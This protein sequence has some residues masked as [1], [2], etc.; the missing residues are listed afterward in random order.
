MDQK[1]SKL[2]FLIIFVLAF[3]LAVEISDR[4]WSVNVKHTKSTDN[5][6]ENIEK[7]F[8]LSI[9]LFSSAM[10]TNELVKALKYWDILQ[11]K[12]SSCKNEWMMLLKVNY[13]WFQV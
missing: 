4:H 8:Y 5:K 11:S 10:N 6:Y 3:N 13:W 1:V 12:L 9:I 7:I 2:L